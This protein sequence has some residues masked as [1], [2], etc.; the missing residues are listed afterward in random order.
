MINRK[1][2]IIPIEYINSLGLR[3]IDVETDPEYLS[4][5]G[6]TGQRKFINKTK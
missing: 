6:A 2:V 4:M 3:T 5:M 1:N